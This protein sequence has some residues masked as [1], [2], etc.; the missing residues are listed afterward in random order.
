MAK[1]RDQ[2]TP[3]SRIASE[4]AVFSDSITASGF[5]LVTTV[6]VIGVLHT[7]VPDHW[8]PIALVARQRAWSQ[9]E[10]ALAAAQAGLGHVVTTLIIGLV[11]WIAGVQFAARFGSVVDTIT[12]IALILFGGWVAIGAWRGL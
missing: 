9:R 12:S 6:A 11:V 2:I 10:T 8:A 3:L 7:A 5:L 4:V 1:S